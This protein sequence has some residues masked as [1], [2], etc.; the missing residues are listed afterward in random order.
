MHFFK[1]RSL[2]WWQ[3]GILKLA[4]ISFGVAVGARWPEAFSS[5]VGFLFAGALVLGA[6]IAFVWFRK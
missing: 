3:L 2:E 6:Y 1:S 5:Y 4:L